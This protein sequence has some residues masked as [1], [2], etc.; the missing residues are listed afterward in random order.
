MDAHSSGLPSRKSARFTR[1]N[2][3]TVGLIVA[4]IAFACYA[5]PYLISH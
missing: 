2:L 4:W 1:L 3:A 5:I